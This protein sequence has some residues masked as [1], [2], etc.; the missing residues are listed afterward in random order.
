MESGSSSGPNREL[1][2]RWQKIYKW[3]HDNL[4]FF[5]IHIIALYVLSYYEMTQC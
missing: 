5:K 3:G 4:N 1:R 2:T